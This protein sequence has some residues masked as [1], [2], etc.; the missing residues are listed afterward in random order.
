MDERPI[1]VLA[2]AR[3]NKEEGEKARLVPEMFA[4]HAGKIGGATRLTAMGASSRVIQREG[5]WSSSAFMVYV[6]DNM[7]DRCRKSC[8]AR[9]KAITRTSRMLPIL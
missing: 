7:D 3:E 9:K 2:K 8:P 5:R 6:R 1:D 4:L